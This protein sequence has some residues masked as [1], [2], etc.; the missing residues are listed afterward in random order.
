MTNKEKTDLTVKVIKDSLV[1]S[2]MP[3]PDEIL[4]GAKGYRIYDEMISD[5]RIGSL[6][7]DR[8]NATQNLN[9][10]LGMPQDAKIKAYA[11]KHLTERN[12]RKWANLLLRG[13]LLYGFRPEEIIW[14]QDEDGYLY[15]DNLDGHR[16]DLY[17]Y[18][19]DGELWYSQY[20]NHKLDEPYKWIV[21]RIHGDRYTNPYGETYLKRCYWP[22][23]FKKMGWK[24]WLTATEKYA[25]PSIVA[26]FDQSNPD[27]ALE[28]AKTLANEIGGI[29]SGSTGAVANVKALQQLSMTGSVS[30]F[31]TLIKACDLQISYAMT[32][33]ALA[34]NVSDTG[35][36]ALGTV[37]E[38]T[39]GNAYENDSR[40]L[41]YTIQ[42]LIDMAIE[43][44]FG[45]T[46]DTLHF[47]YDTGDYA[48]FSEVMT[49]IDHKVPVS[50]KALYTRY[51]IPEPNA[52]IED[53]EFVVETPALGSGLGYEFADLSE[54]GKKKVRRSLLILQKK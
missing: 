50:R 13:A 37:Q 52:D 32:G 28:I 25:V 29:S 46:D 19:N 41:A 33:Q 54:N 35:T 11:E 36:Q 20:G 9:V 18:D 53:D 47:S 6:F 40:A 3:N 21:H 49:A 4:R 34:T 42:R 39:R 31:D 48:S 22:W 38:R 45:S 23:Q 7:E 27:K 15:I 43:V 8:C 17:K 10:L 26:L 5:S 12:L 30:D 16:I 1:F 51:G 44:N 2:S 14:N 24:F